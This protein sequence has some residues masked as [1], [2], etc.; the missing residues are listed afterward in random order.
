MKHK[1]KA[2]YPN[3]PLVAFY[4]TMAAVTIALMPVVGLALAAMGG[5]K[6]LGDR[7]RHRLARQQALEVQRR[8]E[9]A[10]ACMR[11]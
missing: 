10:K 7:S 8:V 4:F 1:M 5:L 6:Y 9:F 11:I 3:S 2:K